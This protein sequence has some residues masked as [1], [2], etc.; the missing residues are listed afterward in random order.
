[1][2]DAV[3]YFEDIKEGEEAPVRSHVLDRTDLVRYAGASYD[4]NP[5]H[6]D[7][8]KAMAA[9]QPSVFGHGMFSMGFLGTAITDFVGIGNVRRYQVRF[10]KQT[11]PD[12]KLST[13]IVVSGKRTEGDDHLVD[14]DVRLVNDDGE[15]KVVGSA[16]AAVPSRS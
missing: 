2:G 4:F 10:A 3:R 14:L 15:E 5:M 1:M 7:E 9:G 8:V 11:W 16:T 12:E 6:H 13:K